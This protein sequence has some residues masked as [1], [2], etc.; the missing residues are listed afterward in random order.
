MQLAKS[1]GSPILYFRGD[2]AINQVDDYTAAG[3]AK[4]T[5]LDRKLARPEL[6]AVET[7][8]Q[9]ESCNAWMQLRDV[10]ADP[11]YGALLGELIAEF[12]PPSEAAGHRR[13]GSPERPT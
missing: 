6:S 8:A 5:F 10:G 9:I 11:E 4:R 1:L 3:T 7:I 13:R 2:H 12:R